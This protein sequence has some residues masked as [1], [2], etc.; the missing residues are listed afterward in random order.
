MQKIHTYWG[1]GFRRWGR[2][3]ERFHL[4]RE[5]ELR[6]SLRLSCVLALL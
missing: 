2:S 4:V 1:R 3:G 5:G 6:L